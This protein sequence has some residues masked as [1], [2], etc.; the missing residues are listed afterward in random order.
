MSRINPRARVS[1]VFNVT[2]RLVQ[3]RP[4]HRSPSVRRRDLAAS[5]AL[6]QPLDHHGGDDLNTGRAQ[7]LAVSAGVASLAIGPPPFVQC[8]APVLPQ[9]KA[10][11]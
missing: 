6:D 10:Q 9:L 8:W 2:S 11:R 5:V 3:H 4:Q 1:L 7:P